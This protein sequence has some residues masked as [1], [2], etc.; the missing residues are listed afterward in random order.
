LFPSF[1]TVRNDLEL[2]EIELNNFTPS[3]GGCPPQPQQLQPRPPQQQ[4]P[5]PL[6]TPRPPTP[7]PNNDDKGKGKGKGKSNGDGSS[8]NN[9]GGSNLGV[10]ILQSLDWYHLD[11]VRDAP[12]STT[13]V[14]TATR[15]ACCT[16]VLRHPGN[17]AC[18]PLPVPPPHQQQVVASTW[19]SWTGA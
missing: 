12:S 7:T 14:S 10:A 18:T 19:S 6:A 13:G 8:D 15:H 9:S 17:T 16:R 4:P 11:V 5:S 3:G 2:E 1:H